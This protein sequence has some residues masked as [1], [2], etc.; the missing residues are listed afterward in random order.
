MSSIYFH[1]K[2]LDAVRVY[3][4]ERAYIN[5]LLFAISKELLHVRDWSSYGDMDKYDVLF[6]SLPNGSFLHQY[7]D[8][9]S[10]KNFAAFWDMLDTCISINNVSFFG[11]DS[12][13]LKA[14]TALAIGSDPIK[15]ATRITSQ[16]EIHCFVQSHNREWL[17]NIIRQG[18]KLKIFRDG[19]GWERVIDM[20]L[21]PESGHI[22]LSYS[23]CDGFY[24][25]EHEWDQ[26]FEALR[27]SDK[28]L[29]LC[30]ENFQDFYFADGWTFIDL[31]NFYNL[32]IDHEDKKELLALSTGQKLRL[33]RDAP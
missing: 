19:Q 16:C 21:N 27:Q 8:S 2:N 12:F 32:Y 31:A 9:I 25:E 15:L 14:N 17:A 29:E 6:K 11:I 33:V 24:P 3:G 18:R 22:V 26:D 30:P 23:V 4:S 20:L 5:N 1:S 28:G 7:K 10:N 13:D